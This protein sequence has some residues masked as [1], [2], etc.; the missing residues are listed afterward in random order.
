MADKKARWQQRFE[1][2]N[3]AYLRFAEAVSWDIERATSASHGIINTVGGDRN[4]LKETLVKRFEL[5]FELA[6]NVL[7]DY[8]LDA[9]FPQSRGS[10]ILTLCRPSS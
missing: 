8:L 7:K 4:I 1:N 5:T 9:G 2:F 3:K 6:R 10:S